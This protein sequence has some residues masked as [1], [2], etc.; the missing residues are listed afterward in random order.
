MTSRIKISENGLTACPSCSVHIRV[1]ENPLA[2]VC[3]FCSAALK[4]SLSSSE[5]SWLSR[6]AKVGRSSLIAASILGMA[7]MAGCEAEVQPVY[8]G[9]PIDTMPMDVVA[10]VPNQPAYGIPAD[11]AL[12]DAGP[13]ADTEATNDTPGDAQP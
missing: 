12:P 6:V 2:T 8:G 10:D 7:G 4:D 3:P 5:T 9:S 11:A 13:A 1:G